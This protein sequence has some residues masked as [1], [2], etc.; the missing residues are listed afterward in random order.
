MGG[1]P[2]IGSS[3]VAGIIVAITGVITAFI[4]WQQ[5][6]A[7]RKTEVRNDAARVELERDQQ[8]L[9]ERRYT[10]EQRDRIIDRLN[11]EI[12]RERTTGERWFE[13]YRAAEGRADQSRK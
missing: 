8:E 13:R 4:G 11:A 2:D 6:R 1:L 12:E 5:A 9:V 3:G 7:G 10:D